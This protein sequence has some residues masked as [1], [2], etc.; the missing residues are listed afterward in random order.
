M[1]LKIT[2][3]LMKKAM[4]ARKP[5]LATARIVYVRA[6]DNDG[7]D[8]TDIIVRMKEDVQT[9]LGLRRNV[10]RQHLKKGMRSTEYSL[11]LF[12]WGHKM[13]QR[14]LR[15]KLN[16]YEY[17]EGL[18]EAVIESDFKSTRRG[19]DSGSEFWKRRSRG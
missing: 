17:A 15:C 9:R 12:K 10:V 14:V 3:A 1:P 13:K 18:D 6:V 16:R 19:S 7:N 5:M 11:L 8:F 2:K 4:K